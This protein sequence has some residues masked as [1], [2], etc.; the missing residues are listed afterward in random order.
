MNALAL[1]LW[2]RALALVCAGVV[3]FQG[4]APLLHQ[5]L[6][7]HV[8]CQQHG[9]LAHGETEHAVSEGRTPP[10]AESPPVRAASDE[11]QLAHDPSQAHQDE[12]CDA[13]SGFQFTSDHCVGQATSFE[14]V[15]YLPPAQG[16]PV[17]RRAGPPLLLVAPKRPPPA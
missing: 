12:H 13:A 4:Q 10:R 15:L 7:T 17:F 3:V 5:V 2:L 9:G 16:E 14:L 6:V 11:S 1:S 8:V